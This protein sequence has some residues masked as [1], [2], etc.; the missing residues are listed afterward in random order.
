M[1]PARSIAGLIGLGD[2][3]CHVMV[4]PPVVTACE[5]L[6]V[7]APRLSWV[8]GRSSGDMMMDGVPGR[9][10]PGERGCGRSFFP[11]RPPVGMGGDSASGEPTAD[12][13]VMGG[14]GHA[15]HMSGGLVN[16]V[17]QSH[18]A[19]TQLTQCVITA[20]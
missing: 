11:G 13:S 16:G 2:E 9:Q 10:L 1:T 8:H 15:L 19:I 20:A 6:R 7:P 18:C 3:A 5:V 12:I 4:V 14:H 17:R